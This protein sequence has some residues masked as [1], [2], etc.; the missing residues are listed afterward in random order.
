V[1]LKGKARDDHLSRFGVLFQGA[2]L[3]DSLS[4]W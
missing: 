1:G 3:F 2:A 4:V